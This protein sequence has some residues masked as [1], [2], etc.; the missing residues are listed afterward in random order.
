MPQVKPK[1]ERAVL[2]YQAGIANVFAV[3][4]FNKEDHGR[5][6]Q[7]LLQHAFSPCEWYAR[8]LAAAGA[9]VA[10]MYCNK[11][12]DIARQ[13]WTTSQEDAPFTESQRP[14]WNEVQP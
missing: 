1:I 9:K 10:T 5:N 11:A 7:R 14:V 8:G 13:P 6:A 4:S 12:G 3:D 2:V